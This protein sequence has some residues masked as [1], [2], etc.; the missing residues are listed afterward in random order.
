[1]GN[2]GELMWRP[3]PFAPRGSRG[4]STRA[5]GFVQ[6]LR[7]LQPRES[8]V[9][10]ASSFEACKPLP[11]YTDLGSPFA[12]C[13]CN[14]AT[15]VARATNVAQLKPSNATSGT[16][17]REGIIATEALP[18]SGAPR[19]P[20]AKLAACAAPHST[21]GGCERAAARSTSEAGRCIAAAADAPDG[22]ARWTDKRCMHQL[23]RDEE[24]RCALIMYAGASGA[25]QSVFLFCPYSD[26]ENDSGAVIACFLA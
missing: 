2:N 22:I 24:D 17:R 8:F 4:N 15:P 16:P 25:R 3:K 23:A 20:I 6:T 11:V 21:G 14:T 18:A 19:A 10:Q 5:A 12:P 1:M 7:R 9:R 13:T 26:I